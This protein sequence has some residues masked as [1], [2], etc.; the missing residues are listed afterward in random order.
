[1][2]QTFAA[3]IL[4]AGLLATAGCF[5]G[6]AA[7]VPVRN[8]DAPATTAVQGS[9]AEP[10]PTA[11]PSP[12]PAPRTVVNWTGYMKVGALYE[13]PSHVDETNAATRAAWSPSFHYDVREVPADL[14]VRL[15]WT[16]AASQLQFMVV[17]PDNATGTET[18][19]E[20]DFADHGPL[21]VKLPADHLTTGDYSIMAHSKIAVDATL[22]FTVSALGGDTRLV[23]TP[24]SAPAQ[25]M[26]GYVSEILVGDGG[27][28]L[29]P[30]ECGVA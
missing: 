29:A 28:S 12:T 15:N 30:R 26:A 9:D 13:L 6:G 20:T 7:P 1:V 22:A 14:E 16:A 11:G 2:R 21:C 4:G 10:L 17:F 8:A 25:D 18:I 24:H 27:G 3:L 19:V 5:A 23:D